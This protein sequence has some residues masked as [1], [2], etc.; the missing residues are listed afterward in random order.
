MLR[1]KILMTAVAVN[2]VCFISA[3]FRTSPCLLLTLLFLML[4]GG[5]EEVLGGAPA[6]S[7]K[8]GKAKKAWNTGAKV[9]PQQRAA[10]FPDT[11]ELGVEKKL[12]F[13]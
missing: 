13:H 11:M 10:Q 3:I 2:V 5:A 8:K 4:R 1:K 7:E 6:A 9:T 12:R